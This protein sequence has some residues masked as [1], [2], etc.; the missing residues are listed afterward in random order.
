MKSL[1]SLSIAILVFCNAQSQNIPNGGFETWTLDQMSQIN[2]PTGWVTNNHH[3]LG[4]AA[5]APVT[6]SSVFHS[7]AYSV[8]AKTDTAFNP[9]TQMFDTMPGRLFT[10]IATQSTPP[11]PPIFI[12]GFAF[13]GHPDSLVGWYTYLPSNGDMAVIRAVTFKRN[14]NGSRDTVAD[15]FFTGNNQVNSF[16]RFSVPFHYHS[17]QM[18]DTAYIEIM[19]SSPLSPQLGS[20][21]KVDD[22]AF[23]S[24]A[25]GVDEI[26]AK[27]LY[28]YFS[29]ENK[30]L[31]IYSTKN[32]IASIMVFDA[33]GKVVLNQKCNLQIGL[34]QVQLQNENWLE[35]GFYNF[36]INT[37]ETTINNK[38]VWRLYKISL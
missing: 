19:S 24:G 33:T 26:K 11:N 37:G 8:E 31:N 27:D 35:Q 18:P 34:Q 4:G 36:K 9:Q 20:T 5:V 21:L 13:T 30:K 14:I 1:A 3:T 15:A 2:N 32:V 10:G 23:A 6:Q 25:N 7:G 22:I 17:Q 16:A 28:A 38:F 29:Y 12:P